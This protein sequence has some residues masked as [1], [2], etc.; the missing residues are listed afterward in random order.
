MNESTIKSVNAHSSRG[1]FSQRQ[2]K[3]LCLSFLKKRDM[4]DIGLLVSGGQVSGARRMLPRLALAG[5]P[6]RGTGSGQLI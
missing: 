4:E 2:P 1:T 5:T 6:R 3:Q